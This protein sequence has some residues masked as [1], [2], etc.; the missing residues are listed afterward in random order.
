MS[1]AFLLLDPIQIDNLPDRLFELGHIT[2]FQSLYRR[3]AY[4]DLLDIGPL[5][6]PVSTDSPLAHAFVRE[7]SATA[8]IWLESEAAEEV[9]L[10][11]LRSLIHVRVEG[12]A[13]VL[14]R[15]YDPRITR[16][17]L[18]DLAP[19]ERDRLMGPVRLIRLPESDRSEGAIRQENP[20]QPIAQYS[21][22]PWL[23]LA[24]AQLDHLS[25]AKR[26]CFAR[27]LIEHC[28]QH[29]PRCLQGQDNAAQLQWA[30]TCQHRAERH[31]YSAVDE[32]T[33]WASFHALLGHDFP[34]APGHAAYR[35][36]LAEPGVSPAQRLDN[37]NAELTRQRLTN[38]ELFA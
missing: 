25:T 36:L 5:L 26:Q 34:D 2:G 27:Q 12:D 31:G 20:E 38:K 17:W 29:F 1:R 23:F 6:V 28:Q 8:G 16:L 15:Y 32:I 10:E 24:P 18:S 9:V 3:T 30:A 21:D 4:S 11:H 22:R 35:Q 7:W 19:P 14:F 13:T 33:R 37:L